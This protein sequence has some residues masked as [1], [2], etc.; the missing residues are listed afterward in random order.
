M[1]GWD[2]ALIIVVHTIWRIAE[3]QKHVKMGRSPA[4]GREAVCS[5]FLMRCDILRA[6]TNSPMACCL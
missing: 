6:A 2:I 4:D 3:G 5:A 1:I